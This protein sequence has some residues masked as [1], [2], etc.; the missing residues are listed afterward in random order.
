MPLKQSEKLHIIY[1]NVAFH[2]IFMWIQLSVDLKLPSDDDLLISHNVGGFS[3]R[4]F[5]SKLITL[6]KRHHT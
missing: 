3:I 6:E 2:L 4:V 1:E 5:Y